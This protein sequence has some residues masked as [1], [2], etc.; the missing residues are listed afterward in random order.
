MK[1]RSRYTVE[2]LYPFSEKEGV[3]VPKEVHDVSVV[4]LVFSSRPRTKTS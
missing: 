1:S 2:R 3:V 4:P